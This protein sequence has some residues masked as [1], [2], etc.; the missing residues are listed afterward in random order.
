M[1]SLPTRLPRL[2]YD[3]IVVSYDRQCRGE[4][5]SL[6]R[7]ATVRDFGTRVVRD[8]AMVP[9]RVRYRKGRKSVV[10]GLGRRR[11]TRE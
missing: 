1:L 11:L 3:P 9:C 2:V 10:E 4:V 5:K 8:P 7:K 6:L